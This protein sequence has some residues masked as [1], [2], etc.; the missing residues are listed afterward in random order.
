[1]AA[2]TK[3][4][5]FSWLSCFRYNSSLKNSTQFGNDSNYSKCNGE[6]IATNCSIVTFLALDGLTKKHFGH[7]APLKMFFPQVTK[8][9][10]F[11]QHEFEK[12][13]SYWNWLY[14]V[15]EVNLQF[16][17]R[18]LEDVLSQFPLRTVMRK[19]I[20]TWPH[21]LTRRFLGMTKMPLLP[22]RKLPEVSSNGQFSWCFMALGGT[23]KA[24]QV[25]FWCEYVYWDFFSDTSWKIRCLTEQHLSK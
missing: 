24:F 10:I 2:A 11:K 7:Y 6:N 12:H 13:N 14:F 5:K 1:M 3:L 22:I 15:R 20:Q 17:E 25:V 19:Y 21:L 4:L 23:W 9:E 18:Y 8:I 16:I